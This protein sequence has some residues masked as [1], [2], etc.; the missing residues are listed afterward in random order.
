M[1]YW[2]YS[3]AGCL[4][5]AVDGAGLI[6][7]SIPPVA[8]SGVGTDGWQMLLRSPMIPL[9]PAWQKPNSPPMSPMPGTEQIP[10]EGASG[11]AGNWTAASPDGAVVRARATRA[12]PAA[13]WAGN[14]AAWTAA[15]TPRSAPIAPITSRIR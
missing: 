8:G 13:A 6:S 14:T 11:W 4:V 7:A 5:L 15:G 3:V 2:S 10:P 12:E 1:P 9:E